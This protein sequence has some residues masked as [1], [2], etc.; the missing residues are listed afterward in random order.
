MAGTGS[1]PLIP[2]DPPQTN[3][4]HSNQPVG[5]EYTL[6]GVMRFLQLEWHRHERERNAW[7][8][9]K[10]ELKQ[11]LAK[12]EGEHRSSRK[13]EESSNLRVRMLERAVLNERKRVKLE[14]N[15]KPTEQ[16]RGYGGTA[17]K[18]NEGIYAKIESGRSR[19]SSSKAERKYQDEPGM[20]KSR[21]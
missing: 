3:G 12:L 11:R 5:T 10:A 1:S 17:N 6:Q 14:S 7:E 8:I 21:K 13:L 15:G 16:E 18:L 2:N 9:E 19:D 4:P 20:M